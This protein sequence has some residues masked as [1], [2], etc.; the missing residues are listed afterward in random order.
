MTYQPRVKIFEEPENPSGVDTGRDGYRVRLYTEKYARGI[1][2]SIAVW[3]ESHER[4]V[5]VEQAFLRG[6]RPYP[7]PSGGWSWSDR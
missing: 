3:V 4:A 2:A 5:E 7:L 1:N 6:D